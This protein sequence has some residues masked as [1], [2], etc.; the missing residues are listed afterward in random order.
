[1]QNIIDAFAAFNANGI[2][3]LAYTI[4]NNLWFILIAAGAICSIT[5][6]LKEEIQ[7]TVTEEQQIL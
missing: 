3:Y 7:L 2:S 5:L 6:S 4:M 1:M